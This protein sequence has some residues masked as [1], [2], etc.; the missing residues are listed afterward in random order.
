MTAM[1]R[2]TLFLCLLLRCL[3]TDLWSQERPAYLLEDD[4]K[5]GNHEGVVE[6]FARL[7]DLRLRV[8]RP[9]TGLNGVLR[10]VN[11]GHLDPE[12][13]RLMLAASFLPP[14]FTT[15]ALAEYQIV[16]YLLAPDDDEELT[17]RHR[18][19]AAKLGH[20]SLYYATYRLPSADPAALRVEDWLT[21]FFVDR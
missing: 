15:S 17:G 21:V 12:D 6:H 4:L 18:S 2:R 20:S 14:E 3:S 8:D 1:F 10:E 9:T 19:T 7:Q 5:T 16:D 13:I 11:A